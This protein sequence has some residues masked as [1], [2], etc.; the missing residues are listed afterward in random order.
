MKSRGWGR[1][2]WTR[3]ALIFA[4][5]CVASATWAQEPEAIVEPSPEPAI[6]ASTPITEFR[7]P[8]DKL[9]KAEALYTTGVRLYVVGTLYGI[10]VLIGVLGLRVSS[11]FRDWAERASARRFVQALVFVPLISLTLDIL[12]LPFGLYR[13][14]LQR[15]YGLSVQSFG[16]WLWDWG[17]AELIGTAI[18]TLLVWGLYAILRHS[19]RRWWLYG[20]LAAV[21][22]ILTLILVQPILIAPLFDTFEPLETKQPALVADLERVMQR[23]G[24]SIER[25]RMLE[26][27]ASDKMT[28]YNAYVSGIGASKR[29]VVWDN[30]SRDLTRAETLF[31]FGHEMGHYVLHHI[32]LNLAFAVGGLLVAMFLAHL[33]IDRVIARFGERWGVR[34]AGDWASLPVLLLLFSLFSIASEPVAS[35]FQRRLEHQADIYGLEVIHGLVPDSSQAAAQAFQKLGEK[36]L[37]YPSPNPLYVFWTFSHPPI[38]DRVRFAL[39]HRPWDEGKPLRFFDD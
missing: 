5:L 37:S 28:T 4:L 34:E 30:T 38:R 32:W 35:V 2:S 39:D 29:V 7:L 16:S 11:R 21:P 26:M 13:Y 25:S 12:N 33:A 31:V 10:A 3:I 27:R 15:E 24:I 14:Q 1:S 23:G 18:A 20:W 19:P 9:E 17:K 22:V 6:E 8:P 36:G